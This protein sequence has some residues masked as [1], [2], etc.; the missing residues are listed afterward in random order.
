MCWYGV[1]SPPESRRGAEINRE[2]RGFDNVTSYFCANALAV[3]NTQLA[4]NLRLKDSASFANFFSAQNAEAVDC[5]RRAVESLDCGKPTEQIIY[6]W[7]AP[8]SGRTHLL[9]AACH[10]AQTFALPFSYLP[11]GDVAVFTPALLDDLE[12]VSLVCLDDLQT[13]AGLRM[14]EEAVFALSERLRSSGGLLVAAAQA[15]V[16]QLALTLPDL[17]TRLT[18]GPTYPL[19]TLSDDEKLAALQLRAVRLGLELAPDVAR[20]VLARYPRDTGSLF[21]WL[22]RV[23]RHSFAAQRRLTIPFLKELEKV[24]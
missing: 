21:A 13:I 2:P 6:F 8:H 17:V 15:P 18:W 14:W 1:C 24:D 22:E 12:S 23:D 9:Q 20:Y 7:G 5:L 4:L 19:Q 3:M 11:F 16:A 10:H